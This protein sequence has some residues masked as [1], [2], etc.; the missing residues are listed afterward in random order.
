MPKSLLKHEASGRKDS[1]GVVIVVT[2]TYDDG[3]TLTYSRGP[4][5]LDGTTEIARTAPTE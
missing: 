3:S 5:L 1:G 4:T 2:L